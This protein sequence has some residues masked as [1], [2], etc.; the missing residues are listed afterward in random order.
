MAILWSWRALERRAALRRAGALVA[1][2]VVVALP[3]HLWAGPHVF[4]QLQRSRRSVSLATPWRPLVELLTGPLPGATVRNLVF[5]AAVRRHGRAGGAARPGGRR[6]AGDR[7][8]G[9]R[10]GPRSC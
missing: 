4:E 1:G 10:C 3:L 2:A 7:R 9:R 8:P 5:A 6:G